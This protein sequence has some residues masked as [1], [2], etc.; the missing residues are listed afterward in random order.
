M[1]E[2]ARKVDYKLDLIVVL[3][4][5]LTVIRVVNLENDCELVECE[6]LVDSE[7]EQNKPSDVER[8][9]LLSEYFLELFYF[10]CDESNTAYENHQLR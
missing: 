4:D 9:A 7:V 2:G 8:P 10:D 5:E 3:Q 6:L 1:V